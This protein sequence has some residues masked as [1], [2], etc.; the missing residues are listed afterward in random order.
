MRSSVHSF[1]VLDK[2][3]GFL[4]KSK[5]FLENI[6]DEGL[7]QEVNLGSLGVLIMVILSLKGIFHDRRLGNQPERP[8][9]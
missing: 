2:H 8:V 9:V 5:R 4:E 7:A 3:S 1:P 6:L